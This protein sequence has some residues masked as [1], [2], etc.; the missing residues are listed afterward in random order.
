LTLRERRL[1]RNWPIK[2]PLI[3]Q[4]DKRFDD[5]FGSP[6]PD[7][8]SRESLWLTFNQV[9]RLGFVLFR[10]LPTFAVAL[11]PDRQLHGYWDSTEIS[12]ASLAVFWVTAE[13]TLNQ[14]SSLLS[15]REH[16]NKFPST[17]A[18]KGFFLAP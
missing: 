3:V 14:R 13:L 5:C 9:C 17:Q 15:C 4:R 11:L 18:G 1:G 7:F 16:Y 8:F 10:R 12:S 2:N 6:V